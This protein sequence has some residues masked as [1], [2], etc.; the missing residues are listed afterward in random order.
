MSVPAAFDYYPAASVDEA[1]SLLQQY[2]DEA[3]LL[4]GGHSLLPTMKLRLA[5][6]GVLID[7]GRIN[8]LSYIREENGVVHVG[9]LATYATLAHSDVLRTHFALLSDAASVLGDPQVRNRGT[10]GGAIAHADPAADMTAIVMAL[11]ADIAV[12]GPN[13]ER[14]IKA[15]DF[16][17]DIFTTALQ[18]DE[19][20]TELRFAIL[21]AHSGTAYMKLENKA[22]H[23]A[24][25][26]CAAVITLGDDGKCSS[27]SLTI[28]GAAVKP[29]RASSTESALVGG[30]LDEATVANAASHAANG[31]EL[32][33]DIHGSQ[34]YRADM[35]KVMM[36]RAIL[37]AAERAR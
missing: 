17:V 11:R 1:I 9:A 23:Y 15:D 14:T 29:T 36:R 18:P 33:S 37:K 8:G 32:V 24:V 16:F 7:I 10:I 2:G 6:P 27:A 21:P 13:G 5:Q 20:V 4:A 31:L 35:T 25:V 30:S 22:S 12:K 26:G 34:A 3:K 19:I 28:T